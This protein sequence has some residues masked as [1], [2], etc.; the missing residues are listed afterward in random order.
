MN[1]SDS[2]GKFSVYSLAGWDANLKRIII[3]VSKYLSR[4]FCGREGRVGVPKQLVIKK[5]ASSISEAV[6]KAGLRLPLGMKRCLVNDLGLASCSIL[7]PFTK[8]IMG[9]VN[10]WGA[11]V[12]HYQW[13]FN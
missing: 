4:N 8:A 10:W 7:L 12:L 3:R 2:Y 13:L 9:Y 11:E 6:N 5:D 1:L